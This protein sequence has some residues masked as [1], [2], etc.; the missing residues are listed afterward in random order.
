MHRTEDAI[1]ARRT[2]REVLQALAALGLLCWPTLC[3]AQASGPTS[4]PPAVPVTPGQPYDWTGFYAGGHLGLA[5]GNSNWTA[6]PGISGT[7]DLFQRIDSFDNGG[8]FFGGL[9]A[10]FNYVLPSRVREAHLPCGCG[11]PC[12][13]RPARAAL[14][15]GHQERFI[16][17]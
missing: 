5:W 1:S 14:W 12:S 2:V 8:S 7:T 17:R 3:A 6:G 15:T 9:Q 4:Q 11:S 13:F 10:G 16:S